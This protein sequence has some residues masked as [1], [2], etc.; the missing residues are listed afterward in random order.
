MKRTGYPYTILDRIDDHALDAREVLEA[1]LFSD[2]VDFYK[3]KDVIVDRFGKESIGPLLEEI[4]EE[5]YGI[6]SDFHKQADDLR[7]GGR[8]KEVESLIESGD[9]IPEDLEKWAGEFDSIAD[10]LNDKRGLPS[11]Q[12]EEAIHDLHDVPYEILNFSIDDTVAEIY[13]YLD[14]HEV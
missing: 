1:L 14:D 12:F 4:K 7:N 10:E 3:V 11:E 13:E 5:N 6:V 9:I 2:D 8:Q